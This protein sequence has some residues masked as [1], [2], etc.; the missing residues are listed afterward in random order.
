MA[1]DRIAESS[2]RLH[3]KRWTV[4][5]F[6]FSRFDMTNGESIVNLASIWVAVER[7][8]NSPQLGSILVC[9]L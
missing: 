4:D 8:L 7:T 6:Q 3:I 1:Y 5:I 9:T 2:K